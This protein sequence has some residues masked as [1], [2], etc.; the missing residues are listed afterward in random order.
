M[1]GIR[2]D[3]RNMSSI[4]MEE[5]RSLSAAEL[6]FMIQD[7]GPSRRGRPS[8]PDTRASGAPRPAV[9]QHRLIRQSVARVLRAHFVTCILVWMLLVTVLAIAVLVSFIQLL[10][11]FS[12]NANAKCDVAIKV[13][14][15]VNIA[16]V[17]YANTVHICIVNELNGGEN[18]MDGRRANSRAAFT[19]E[20][21]AHFW[22]ILLFLSGLIITLEAETCPESTPQLYRAVERYVWLGFVL[23][24]CWL[25]TSFSTVLFVFLLRHSVISTPN[26]APEGTLDLCR[27]IKLG[28]EVTSVALLGPSYLENTEEATCCIC[29]EAFGQDEEVRVTPCKHLFHPSC[30]AGWFRVDHTCPMCRHDITSAEA[31]QPS[32]ASPAPP[33]FSLGTPAEPEEATD[34]SISAVHGEGSSMVQLAITSYVAQSPDVELTNEQK[35]EQHQVASASAAAAAVAHASADSVGGIEMELELPEAVV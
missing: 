16:S 14:I 22:S 10:I 32:M 1:S 23:S 4:Q 20:M 15:W 34:P 25:V 30:I 9:P 11:V 18:E 35:E 19:Y 31:P 6:L 29:L 12:K 26:A 33:S 13:F 7:D 17:I 27:S 2:V 3:G 8:Q 21:G 28:D 24:L 5:S